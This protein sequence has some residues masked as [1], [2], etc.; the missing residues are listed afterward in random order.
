MLENSYNITIDLSECPPQN[1]LDY[2]GNNIF[3]FT[4]YDSNISELFARKAVEVCDAITNKSTFDYIKNHDNYVWFLLMCNMPFFS[5]KLDWGSSI[6]GAW[7]RSSGI[8]FQSLGI[9]IDDEQYSESINFDVEEW[10]KFISS[11]VEF[12]SLKS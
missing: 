12:S 9:W 3:D 4:T 1:R 7:W 5:N 8:E 2:L 10:E 11:I 6:R